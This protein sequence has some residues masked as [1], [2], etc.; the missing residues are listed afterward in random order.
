[1]TGVERECEFPRFD[2]GEQLW[3]PELNEKIR[4][5]GNWVTVWVVRSFS[6]WGTTFGD[7]PELYEVR[8]R[9]GSTRNFLPHALRYQPPADAA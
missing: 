9:D 7:Y 1:M 8:Y 3:T 4:H 6:R 2:D 5:T